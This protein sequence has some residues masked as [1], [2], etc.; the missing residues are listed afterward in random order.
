M[1]IIQPAEVI[2]SVAVSGK[3][4]LPNRYGLIKFGWSKY[5]INDPSAGIFQRRP[6]KKGQIFVQEKHYW[7]VNTISLALQANR[8]KFADGMAAWHALPK[9]ERDYYNSLH[10]PQNMSGCNRFL[11]LWL[12]A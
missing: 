5:G 6:R 4:S 2:K 3:Y 11:R 12:K 7:P 9:S 8:D 1:V 10:Q